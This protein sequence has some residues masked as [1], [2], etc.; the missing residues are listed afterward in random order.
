MAH[1]QAAI[2]LGHGCLDW[3]ETIHCASHGIRHSLAQQQFSRHSQKTRNTTRQEH[4]RLY[5]ACSFGKSNHARNHLKSHVSDFISLFQPPPKWCVLQFSHRHGRCP[6]TQQSLHKTSLH[7]HANAKSAG[8]SA[9]RVGRCWKHYAC[10][11][12]DRPHPA[13]PFDTSP[14]PRRQDQIIA[15][16]CTCHSILNVPINHKSYSH[17]FATGSYLKTKK[18]IN[19]A[20]KDLNK[21]QGYIITALKL[22]VFEFLCHQEYPDWNPHVA[23]LFGDPKFCCSKKMK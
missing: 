3:R 8:I 23:L 2:R 17:L 21:D 14:I 22:Y 18:K 11:Q 12:T 15:I 7:S 4:W 20:T 6:E 5:C 13:T 16:Y 10:F 1:Q 19:N 9:Q